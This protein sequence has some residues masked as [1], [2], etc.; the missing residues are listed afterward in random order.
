MGTYKRG[1]LWKKKIL[2]MLFCSKIRTVLYDAP[3]SSFFFGGVGGGVGVGGVESSI[4]EKLAIINTFGLILI[5]GLCIGS[6]LPDEN[7]MNRTR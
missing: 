3:L 6:K 2:R 5:H 4:A 1:E 7:W